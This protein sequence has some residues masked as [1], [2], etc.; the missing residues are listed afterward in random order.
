M[1]DDYRNIL[2]TVNIIYL[3]E[4]NFYLIYKVIK[5]GNFQL[6]CIC[7]RTSPFKNKNLMLEKVF[8][9]CNI[10]KPVNILG[11]LIERKPWQKKKSSRYLNS[12]LWFN[13]LFLKK[14]HLRKLIWITLHSTYALSMRIFRQ[15]QRRLCPV[16]WVNSFPMLSI[17]GWSEPG[18][19]T[20]HSPKKIL[21]TKRSEEDSEK[22]SSIA[23][24]QDLAVRLVS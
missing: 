8:K 2:E 15:V 16:T 20:G 7:K 9:N 17:L 6:C 24:V 5:D 19:N 12:F 10:I 14:R 22:L 13:S 18:T 4:K 3:L 1:G 11:F 21:E 23:Y